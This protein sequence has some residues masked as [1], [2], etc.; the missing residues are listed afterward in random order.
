MCRWFPH[1]RRAG[2]GV[3]IALRCDGLVGS[4]DNGERTSTSGRKPPGPLR[5]SYSRSSLRDH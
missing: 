1:A 5:R 2:R 3:D 4:R